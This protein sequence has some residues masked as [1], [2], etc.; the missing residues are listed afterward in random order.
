MNHDWQTNMPLMS[1]TA[2]AFLPPATIEATAW[3]ILLA[4]HW[5]QHCKLSLEKLACLVSVPQSAL[6]EW[7]GILEE[8]ELI[9]GAKYGSD[10]ELRAVLTPAGRHLLDQYLSA[11]ACLQISAHH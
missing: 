11:T 2:I 9:T 4:L 8:R 10:R 5:D 6:N 7:L 1:R 3:D